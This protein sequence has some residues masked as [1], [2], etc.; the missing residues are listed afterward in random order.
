MIGALEHAACQSGR[1]PQT[2]TVDN[3]PEFAGKTLDAWAYANDIHLD[4]IRPDK[5][6]ELDYIESFN[7]KLRDELLNAEIFFSLTEA[8]KTL[9]QHRLDYYTKRSTVLCAAGHRPNTPSTPWGINPRPFL[10]P[11]SSHCRWPKQP[12]HFITLF[13]ECLPNDPV[14]VGHV[15]LTKPTIGLQKSVN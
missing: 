9:E 4:F 3:G 13:T 1:L 15:T 5:P 7:G 8:R 2:I 10:Y 6:T 11:K 14:L 12:E